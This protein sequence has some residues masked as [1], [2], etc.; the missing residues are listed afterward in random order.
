M[1]L[2]HVTCGRGAAPAGRFVS[3]LERRLRGNVRAGSRRAPAATRVRR[4]HVPGQRFFLASNTCG[5]LSRK[6]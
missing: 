4:E 3:P 1:I 6:P 2:P 5:R